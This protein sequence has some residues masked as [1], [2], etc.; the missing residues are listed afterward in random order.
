MALIDTRC[1]YKLETTNNWICSLDTFKT[2]PKSSIY[3]SVAH[4]W[5]IWWYNADYL[6]LGQ[7][8]YYTSGNRF[9]FAIG[10]SSVTLFAESEFRKLYGFCE[11]ILIGQSLRKC[12][13][14]NSQIIESFILT[15]VCDQRYIDSVFSR[16]SAVFN[17]LIY[18]N[19]Y[20]MEKRENDL[21]N[22]IWV[23]VWIGLLE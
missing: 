23:I 19:K 9:V 14:R 20:E 7:S 6:G 10:G 17:Y 3:K 5:I 18:A 4:F 8:L 21:S 22:Y 15:V 1:R 16:F 2:R 11:F 12:V 13:V